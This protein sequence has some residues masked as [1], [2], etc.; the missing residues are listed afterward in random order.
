MIANAKFYKE[1]N[2]SLAYS[3]E[4]ANKHP[5]QTKNHHKPK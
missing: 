1:N 4:H 2:A 5:K 3:L